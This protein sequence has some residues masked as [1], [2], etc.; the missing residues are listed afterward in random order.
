M[1]GQQATIL[2]QLMQTASNSK[3]NQEEISNHNNLKLKN[4]IIILLL[5]YKYQ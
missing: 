2:R 3:L 4:K 1:V 5:W